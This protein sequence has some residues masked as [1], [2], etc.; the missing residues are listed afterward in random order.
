VVVC[1]AVL[2]VTGA[3]E[4]VDLDVVAD[5]LVERVAEFGHLLGRDPALGH[6]GVLR[7]RKGERCLVLLDLD[8]ELLLGGEQEVGDLE[9]ELLKLILDRAELRLELLLAPV[10][11]LD[12][13]LGGGITAVEVDV[14]RLDV[15]H[16]EPR[17]RH[18]DERVLER[19]VGG[20][21]EGGDRRP[22]GE[23]LVC[24]DLGVS[25]ERT[26]DGLGVTLA[27]GDRQRIVPRQQV[28]VDAEFGERLDRVDPF[29]DRPD[30]VLEVAPPVVERVDLAAD[31]L[32]LLLECLVGD[33]PA[34]P[35][36]LV[37][38]VEGAPERAD[39]DELLGGGVGPLDRVA[40]REPL[41]GAVVVGD[42]ESVETVDRVHDILHDGPGP[43]HRHPAHPLRS[44]HVPPPR[45]PR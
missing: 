23:H 38:H 42:V 24:V 8:G 28:E 36:V 17:E 33:E 18:P 10:E 30:V 14:E 44:E 32:E 45:S 15:G 25:G 29:L 16:V 39:G 1:V 27:D 2:V 4:L 6:E 11:R 12:V 40:G 35:R 26:A 34:R 41:P 5:G 21:G 31:V 37:S 3:L 9:R 22:R 19:C 7:G 43:G 13:R 20:I